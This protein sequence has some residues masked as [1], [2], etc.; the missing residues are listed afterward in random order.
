M[1]LTFNNRDVEV[2]KA[3]I[4]ALVDTGFTIVTLP[5]R[6]QQWFQPK[7]NYPNQVAA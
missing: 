4:D 5:I 2:W 7:P 1:S 3:L 6:C